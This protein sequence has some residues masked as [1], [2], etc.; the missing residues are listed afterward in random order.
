MSAVSESPRAPLSV[1]LRAALAAGMVCGAAFGI[2]DALVAWRIGTAHLD[3]VAWLGCAAGAVCEYVLVWS[4][5]LFVAA[6]VLRP[7]LARRPREAQALAFW[8]IALG[9]GLFL[10]LYWWTRPYLFYGW[11]ALSPARIATTIGIALAAIALA[12]FLARPIERAT[13]G[14]RRVI[15]GSVLVVAL[16]GLC[17]LSFQQGALGTRGEKVTCNQHVPNVLLVVVDALRQDTLGCYGHARVK[18]PHIDR[19]AAEGVVF[20]NAF[21]QAPFTLTSFGSFLTGKYPRRHGLVSMA[22]DKRMRRDNVT[23]PSHLK[24][25]CFDEEEKSS[26]P[27]LKPEDWLTASFHTGA[28]SNGSG[29]LRGFDLYYEQ[30]VGHGIVIADSPWSV[31][32]SDLL[33]HVI[34]DKTRTKVMSGV[35]GVSRD[36]LA[37]FG[38]QRFMAMVHLY[39][40]HTPYDPKREFRDM[41]LDPAYKGSFKSFYAVDRMAIDE[42]ERTPDAADLEQIRNLYYA[43]V[44]Q[45]DDDIGKL[46]ELLRARDLLDD[47]LVI[48]LSDHGE[49]LGE[50]GLGQELLLEHDHMVQTNLRIPLVMRWPKG[51]RA[52]TRVQALVDE[53]DLLPTICDLFGVAPPPQKDLNAKVDGATL[54][55]LFTDAHKSV[56]EYSFAENGPYIAAQD[57]RWKLV[58][59]CALLSP[60]AWARG[61]SDNPGEVPWLIDLQADPAESKNVL[62]EHPDVVERMLAA[63]RAF[64]TAMPIPQADKILSE[65]E[66]EQRRLDLL[67]HGYVGTENKRTRKKSE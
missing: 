60:E 38:D 40:T 3:F 17:Y 5:G 48:V 33:L 31:F 47:T 67:R 55:P 36:W 26:W 20:E 56:R 45:A 4:A 43:G 54:V 41:Y 66:I 13:R 28:I 6:L 62:A 22:P 59:P 24:Q 32:R 39:S 46:V 11:N 27:C 25:A 63:L 9:I 1:T 49:S 14:S 61:T 42:G 50:P 2:V 64:D 34:A 30:M 10:E 23:L 51:I 18:S 58:V 7:L 57:L 44:S 16:V 29:L 15:V 12:F 35:P 65:R 52:G 37:E 8:R 19:L 21:T 53:I